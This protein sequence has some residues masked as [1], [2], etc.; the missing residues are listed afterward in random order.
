MLS[1]V[2]SSDRG[3]VD[4]TSWL[5]H[6]GESWATPE[7]TGSRPARAGK[8]RIITHPIGHETGWTAARSLGEVGTT[9]VHSKPICLCS[10]CTFLDE[11]HRAALWKKRIRR[12]ARHPLCGA[13]FRPHPSARDEARGAPEELRGGGLAP[14][15]S[16]PRSI[17]L[18]AGT[19]RMLA[20]IAGTPPAPGGCRG[21]L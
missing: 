1:E 19:E 18:V 4:R 13:P 11:I 9:S 15:L 14:S 20:A 12:A 16:P 2:R 10:D 21:H 7:G 3:L 6:R 17:E 5:G 8:D